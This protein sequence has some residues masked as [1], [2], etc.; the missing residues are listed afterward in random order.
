MVDNL[1]K[2]FSDFVIIKSMTI[3]ITTS[4]RENLTLRQR[5]QAIGKE[6]HLPVIE[7]RKQSVSKL[8]QSREALL[9][10]Y[11]DELR[12][13][14]RDGSE[15]VFHPDTAMLRIKSEHDALLTLLGDSKLQILDT[16]MGLASDSIVMASVGN[17]VTAIESNALIHFIVSE[18]LA[19]YLSENQR[20][21]T[22]MRSI[23]TYCAD[24]ITY[25]KSLSDKSFDVVYCDPMFSDRISELK[26]LDGLRQFANPSPLSD[27]FLKEAKRVAR[28]SIIIKAH[29]R[30]AVFET[31]GFK[32]IE[33]PAQKFHYGMIEI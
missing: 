22:A 27:E 1:L 16:T 23:K 3:A 14:N 31:Y 6:L 30:D 8:L 15:L 21:M 28:K 32:R 5:A 18:G 26:N 17:D 24:N 20:L 19:T 2:T 11:N 4:L 10:V 9:L 12:L 25:M 29:F 13:V 7:R 33:R